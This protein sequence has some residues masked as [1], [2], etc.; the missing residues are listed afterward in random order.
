MR[1]RIDHARTLHQLGQVWTA[2]DRYREILTEDPDNSEV[3]YRI[4]NAL[5][6]LGEFEAAL[7]S[8]DRAIKVKPDYSAAYCNR[9]VLLGLMHRLPE[10]LQSYDRAIAIDPNDVLARCNRGI[11]LSGL[12]RKD[13]ALA[14]FNAAIAAQANYFPAL[15]GRGA[16]LQE[17]K[18]WHAALETYDLAIACNADDALTFYNRGNVLKALQR[19]QAA[20]ASYK[21]AISV[22]SGFFEAYEA[23]AD[24]LQGLARLPEALANID[25]AIRINPTHASTFNNRGVILQRLGRFDE[26][27]ESLNRSIT[28]NANYADPYVNRGAVMQELGLL[29][30]AIADYKQSIAIDEDFAEG[31]CNLALAYLKSG[32]F[33][34]GWRKYEWRWRAKS[35]PAFKDKRD[36]EEPLWLGSPQIAGKTILLYGE[37]GLGDSLQFCRY[38]EMVAKLGPNIILE[39]PESLVSLCLSLSGVAQIVAQGRSLPAFDIQCP[40]MSL[41]LAFGTTLST[42]PSTIPYLRPELSKVA[43]WS[44]RLGTKLKPRIGLAW[45]GNKSSVAHRMRH[46][47]LASLISYLPNDF[48]YVCLQTD[49]DEAGLTTLAENPQILHFGD[50]LKGFSNTAAVC[51]CMDLIISVDTSIAHLSGALGKRTWLLLAFN[52]DWRWMIGREDTPWYPTMRLYRQKSRGG[53]AEVFS[54]VARELNA[55]PTG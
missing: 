54:R 39:V 32:E 51:E 1:E 47:E 7:L 46:F 33:V 17:S 12:G 9:A 16:L 36:F 45:T 15:F 14:S 40:L 38:V 43:E 3:N 24:V 28:L 23:C 2:I 50:A 26:A 25:Q 22:S 8:Y 52:S 30:D 19:L 4:A 11:L 21:Q 18:Q 5:K 48:Q 27:L 44:D 41:P 6:D 37:Q 34:D 42:I 53:W 29:S 10:A 35:N 49:V 13:E 55:D 20:L 31:H